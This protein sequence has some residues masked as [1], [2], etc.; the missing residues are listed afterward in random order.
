NWTLVPT[1]D[2]YGSY[3]IRTEGGKALDYDT[4]QNKIQL[5]HYLGYNNQR[6]IISKNDN[7]TVRITSVHNGKALE[8]SK[9]GRLILNDW[10]PEEEAQQWISS[11]GFK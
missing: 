11:A 7:E 1:G 9:D 5:Y 10:S 3:S 2:E 4:G 6:W 8:I